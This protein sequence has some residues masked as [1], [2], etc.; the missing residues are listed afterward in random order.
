MRA[1]GGDP[2]AYILPEAPSGVTVKAGD[3]TRSGY[4]TT[5]YWTATAADGQSRTYSVTVIRDHG[6]PTAEEAFKPGAAKDTD[7]QTP[8]ASR[9]DTTLVSHGYLLDGEYHVVKDTDYTIPEDGTFAYA[10][11]QGQ[12]VQVSESKVRGMTW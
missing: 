5:Q 4:A 7:G 8:A 6:T 10:S 3:V 12:T 9:D 2:G 11:K 1:N